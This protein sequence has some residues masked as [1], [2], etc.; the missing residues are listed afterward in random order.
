LEPETSKQSDAGCSTDHGQIVYA[1]KQS[2]SGLF[3]QFIRTTCFD[4]IR[5]V[6]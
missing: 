5:V 1:G 2:D 6:F 4:F 3:E